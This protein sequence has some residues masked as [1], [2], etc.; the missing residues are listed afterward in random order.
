[1]LPSVWQSANYGPRFGVGVVVTNQQMDL[2]TQPVPHS[3][4]SVTVIKTSQL[5]LYREII[6]VCNEIRTERKL[7]GRN[8][9][10][11]KLDLVVHKVTIKL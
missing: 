4:H 10:F 3:K 5:M 6:A 1:M 9:E 7:C 11:W 8:A 2:K